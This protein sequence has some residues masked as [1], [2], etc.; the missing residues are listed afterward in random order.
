MAKKEILHPYLP[1]DVILPVE[2]SENI[3]TLAEV[4]GGF[5][6]V[7]GVVLILTFIYAS[8]RS[9]LAF[10]TRLKVCWF[11][12]CA[13]IHIVL[14]GYF[15][16]FWKRI[17]GDQS[18]LSQLCKSQDSSSFCNFVDISPVKL[19]HDF[20]AISVFVSQLP[21]EA[22]VVNGQTVNTVNRVFPLPPPPP[23]TV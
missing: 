18:F 7:V 9:H 13:L 5:F 23:S 8:T 22:W 17:A 4:L 6:V 10:G 16:L 1:Q 3:N 14:E 2:Y 21:V 20:W 12:V 11:V 15:S 19:N